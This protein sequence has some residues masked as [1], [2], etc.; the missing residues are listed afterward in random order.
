M[1]L[2]TNLP[3]NKHSFE[4]LDDKGLDDEGLDDKGM[5]IITVYELYNIMLICLRLK[6]WNVNMFTSQ[7]W[8]VT[9]SGVVF[10][11]YFQLFDIMIIGN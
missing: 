6:N 1:L 5:L 8:N 2:T 4:G 11:T 7:D 3:F 9:Q 10:L